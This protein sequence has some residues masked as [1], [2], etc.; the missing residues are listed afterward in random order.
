[1]P[2]DSRPGSPKDWLKHAESDLELACIGRKP[3]I[4][5][6]NLTFHA[7]QAAEKALKALLLA[8]HRMLPKTHNIRFLLDQIA[9]LTVVPERIQMAALLTDY[10][11]TMRYPGDFEPITLEEYNEAIDLA[12]KVLDWTW[13]QIEQLQ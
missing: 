5:L 9:I 13:R 8:H 12:K 10:A 11:V 2:P 7:Q 1:M 3:G 6:E 4:L